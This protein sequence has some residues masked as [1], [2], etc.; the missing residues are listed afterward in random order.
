[1]LGKRQN[2]IPYPSFDAIFRPSLLR[3]QD[4]GVDR[5]PSAREDRDETAPYDVPNCP[6]MCE[7]SARIQLQ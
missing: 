3:T 2:W 7:V 4:I 5:D 6:T 1:M